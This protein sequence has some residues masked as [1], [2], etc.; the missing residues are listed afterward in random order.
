MRTWFDLSL[1]RKVPSPM[2]HSRRPLVVGLLVAVLAAAGLLPLAT[3]PAATGAAGRTWVVDAVD[4]AYGNRWESVDTL[5]SE[6]RIAVGDTVEWQF[7][8]AAMAHDL[9]SED[10][11]AVWP[12]PI[13]E[14]RDI[15]GPPIRRT[16]SAPGTYFYLCSI[17]GTLMRGSVVVEEPGANRAPVIAPVVD[18]TSGPAPLLVHA[19]AN[20]TDPDGD[21]L[22]YHWD[23]GTAD[24]ASDTSTAAHAMYAYDEPGAFTATLTVSDGRGGVTSEQFP[25]SAEAASPVSASATPTSGTAPLDVAFTAAATTTGLSYAWS[26]GDGT[27]GSGAS[28]DHTYDEAGSYIATLTASDAGGV[29]GTDTVAIT[30]T[31]DGHAHLPTI[32]ATATP[33]SVSA[34]AT[35]A[36]STEVTTTGEL[37]SYSDGLVSFPE[38]LGTAT[39]VRRRGS[40]TASLAVSGLRPSTA[41]P[42]VHVHEQPC[43][44]DRGGAHFRFDETQ[45][46]SAAN[47]I[48]PTFT[49]DAGGD[50]AVSV[51]QPLRAGARAVSVVVHD[52]DNSAKRIGCADL[53]P[54]TG[55]LAYSWAFGDGSTGTGPDP[56]HTYA[57][58]G[59]YTA[60]VTVR[61]VHDGHGMGLDGSRTA[62]VPVVVTDTTAPDTR[63][64]GG[65]T[66]TVASGRAAFRLTSE[67]GATFSCRLDARAW[68]PC[69][70]APVLRG[71][72][73]G[74]HRLQ[75]RATDAAGNTDPTPAVRTWTVD[76]TGPRVRDLRPAGSTRDRTPTL[77]ARVTD[78]RSVVGRVVLRID[79]RPVPGLRLRGDRL[80]ATPRRALAPG[81][82]VVRLVAADA[83][84][85]R[86]VRT[87]RFTVRR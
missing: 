1:A 66:G 75:V 23:F 20:A 62:S 5:T 12:E 32:V 3:A 86:T 6:V 51:E 45:P 60:S 9:T 43:A 67:P 49:S 29:V 50:A 42:N 44:Q 2:S 78:R 36:F 25:I 18:P 83:V 82:H 68:S 65:P 34:P 77:R 73:D 72:L 21:P 79:G 19:T 57:R 16:F 46:F 38:L 26:F 52:P 55:E 8:R 24:D 11:R 76:T 64:T 13:L 63:I 35:V 48:W 27:T 61:S 80:T 58:A 4:D 39:L 10:T 31:E 85:N 17:H 41:H 40:T 56:D 70:A 14:H 28:P 30:A 87:W 33:G 59:R 74:G 37:R 53:A 71:L 54:A 84:G 15:D 81:R 47:E 69:S 22:T 7:D